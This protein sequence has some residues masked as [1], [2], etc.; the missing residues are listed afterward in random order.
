MVDQARIDEIASRLREAR[1][2][3]KLTATEAAAR[4][5]WTP[6]TYY[7]HE[8]GG[9]GIPRSRIVD[10][11]RAF[12]VSPNW[13]L[14][15]AIGPD[16]LEITRRVVVVGEVAAGVWQEEETW[17]ERK[18]DDIPAMPGRY[19]HL[20]QVAYLVRGPSMD[21]ERIFDGDFVICVTYWQTRDAPQ[22]GDIV[23]VTRKNGSLTERTVKVVH[24]TP[25][26]VELQPRSSDPRFQKP[27]VIPHDNSAPDDMSVEITGLVIGVHRRI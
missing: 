22:E 13:L 1:A 8:N 10:Y 20:E 15:G 11:A 17:D 26:C 27:I 24:V 25:K 4:F 2:R 3:A 19:E 12:K 6:S 5:G 16:V 23:L 14:T 21:L 9:R 18:Y 7:G